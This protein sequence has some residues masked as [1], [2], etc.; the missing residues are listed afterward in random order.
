MK[1]LVVFIFSFFF[2]LSCFGQDME[3][4]ERENSTDRIYSISNELGFEE[5]GEIKLIACLLPSMELAFTGNNIKSYNTTTK[6]IVFDETIFTDIRSSSS[7]IFNVYIDNELVFENIKVR[8]AIMSWPI[9]GW[10]FHFDKFP[11][12]IY[13]YYYVYNDDQHL[14]YIEEGPSESL[15]IFIKYLSDNNKIITNIDDIKTDS[16]VKIYSSGKTIHVNN[17][18][19]KNTVVTVYGITGL[20]VAEQTMS[21][22]TTTLNLPVSGF[23]IVSV[24]AENEKPVTTKVVVR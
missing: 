13:L 15:D 4:P 20:K 9:S 23:Y 8:Y 16:P 21:S 12:K 14:L 19:G 1:N 2:C 6:E 22:Q 24:K 7:M 11:D 18:T 5:Y 3:M 10:A 17:T